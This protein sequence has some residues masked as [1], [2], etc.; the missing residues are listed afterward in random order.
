[1]DQTLWIGAGVILQ[2]PS[3]D[4]PFVPA[5]AT[6]KKKAPVDL[7]ASEPG[8]TIEE[9]KGRHP[10]QYDCTQNLNLI[11]YYCKVGAHVAQSSSYPGTQPPETA[12]S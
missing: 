12:A 1:M 7:T 6:R 10:A 4:C 11:N 2:E 9:T 5:L 3:P 8:A